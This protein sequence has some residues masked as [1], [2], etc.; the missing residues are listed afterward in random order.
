M[1]MYR[2][3]KELSLTIFDFK[4]PLVIFKENNKANGI[5]LVETYTMLKAD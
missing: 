5:A 4:I 2:Y 1:C 3:M